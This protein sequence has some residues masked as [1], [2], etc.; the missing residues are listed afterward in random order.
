MKRL[1]WLGLLAIL[2][3]FLTALTSKPG[4]S[5]ASG[6]GQVCC[7]EV[8]ELPELH[9]PVTVKRDLDGVPHISARNDHDAY[10]VQGFLHARDRL[11]QMDAARRL[12][13]GTL[14]ELVGP[15]ALSDDVQLRTL[16]FR[17]GAQ[18]SWAALPSW[19]QANLRAYA[20]GVNAFLESDS[21]LPDEY[22]ALELSRAQPWHPLDT[23]VILKGVLFSRTFDFTLE[24]ELTL[25]LAEF[26]EAGESGG[27][28]GTAL[29]FEDIYR[30]QPFY[31]AV[32][33][34]PS[35][36]S[37]SA[38][39]S[40]AA[41]S[42]RGQLV[43]VKRH[44]GGRFLDALRRWRDRLDL[45][46][47]LRKLLSSQGRGSNW[48]VLSGDL[49][50]SGRPILAGDPHL[51][52]TVPGFWYQNQLIVS[53]DPARGNL[54]ASG[55]SVPGVP[56]VG[57]GCNQRL[58]WTISTN[59]LDLVDTFRET[60]MLD[61]Q[62]LPTHTVYQ[63][64][65]EAVQR[66]AQSFEVNR[67]GNGVLDDR[68]TA[69]VGAA[70]GGQTF[71]VPRRLS[72]PLLIVEPT[73]PN[74]GVGLSV[75]N[76]GLAA[77]QEMRS[78]F[79]LARTTDFESFRFAL[80]YFDTAFNFGYADVD[81]NIGYVATGEVPLREDLEVLQ[82]VDGLPPYLIRDGSGSVRNEW[83]PAQNA[84]PR[85]SL[86]FAI[87]PRDA[88][89]ASFNPESGYLVSANNDPSGLL[90]DNDLFD[91]LRPDGGVDYLLA[92]SV[93]LRAGKINAL[94]E[95]RLASGQGG[96]DREAAEI[97][98][99]NSQFPDAEVLSP[100]VVQ[101]F[102][103]AGRAEAPP[104]LAVLAADGE[105]TEAVERLS[106]WDFSSPTGIAQGYDAG[107]DPESLPQPSPQEISNSVAA[108][109]YATWRSAFLRRVLGGTLQ[110]NGI[111]TG[112]P[113]TFE[114]SLA[115]VRRLLEDFP[116]S[117][118][119][120][121]SGLDFFHTPE[122]LSAEDERDLIILQSL[123][124]AL[125]VLSGPTL[126]PAFNFSS[127]QSDYRWGRLHRVM[128]NHPLGGAFSI[129]PSGG[130]SSLAPGLPGLARAGGFET[131]DNGPDGTLINHANSLLY[132]SGASPRWI[133]RLQQPVQ[134][135]FNQ[136]GGQSGDRNSPHYADLL[137]DWLTNRYRP[138]RTQPDQVNGALEGLEVLAPVNQRLFYP[139]DAA[140]DENFTAF[141]AANLSDSAAQVD[142]Q[143][144]SASGDL[145]AQ[146]SEVLAPQGQSARLGRELF[147]GLDLSGR[148]WV[149]IETAL[150][151]A[152]LPDQPFLATFTQ[153]GDFALRQLDGGVAFSPPSSQLFFTRV[154]HGP[155][156]F[157]G[158][159]A[160]TTLS[161]VNPQDH[162]VTL[163][164]RW[165]RP[166]PEAGAISSQ[167]T[168]PAQGVL[169]E[170]LDSLFA[171]EDLPLQ[172]GYLRVDVQDGYLAAASLL[173]ELVSDQSIFLLNATPGNP[174]RESFSAQLAEGPSIFTSLKLVNT[175]QHVRSLLIHSLSEDGSPLQAPLQV[176]LAP[177]QSW[178]DD[179]LAA[180]QG[181]MNDP[182][183][184]GQSSTDAP[185]HAPGWTDDQLGAG[186]SPTDAPSRAPGSTNDPIAVKQGSTKGPL[187][188]Q[189]NA[190]R[191]GSLRVT[192]DGPGVIGDVVFGDPV[193][194][195]FV[196]ALPLQGELL[197][198]AVFP[199]VANL[200][201]LFFT[202]LAFHN[203]S[204]ADAAEIQIRVLSSQGQPTGQ[205]SLSLAPG[206]R[207]S[208]TLTELIP[209]TQ[210]QQGGLIL[211]DSD[212]PI[213]AQALF[214]TNTLTLLSAVPLTNR[215]P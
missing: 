30:T 124:E 128:L 141:A 174:H 61:G 96:F 53:G 188:A 116:Q 81:G 138:L 139:F 41:K 15:E 144:R 148:A 213:V 149:G 172:G 152:P 114:F 87:V 71:I 76:T 86:P 181:S 73:G 18:E 62:G 57:I 63:G 22:A 205:G 184:T 193:Q 40:M 28:D 171:N 137:G 4:H 135:W 35:A 154:H 84:E 126:A 179:P 109:L 103:R 163:T 88:M 78:L 67:L 89:P 98:Q 6:A 110:R 177:G 176:D 127:N 215:D 65:P 120:G 64:Q 117:Q 133:A 94:I 80:D 7:T 160:S 202:G 44:L 123:N 156:A 52:L 165:I 134:A 142:W 25:N 187:A 189:Q 185:A 38:A 59:P 58:C 113:D 3:L 121:D 19:A 46:P 43:S 201:G 168:L 203:P 23:L 26:Q 208:Q 5:Q 45:S 20:Q 54:D 166:Q 195:S 198:Q 11:F 180:E 161:V 39:P 204:E 211:I 72:G 13:S 79:L 68:L 51:D 17:R 106:R 200:E 194:G 101:A 157:R 112:T 119:R 209:A 147:Q 132:D 66:I 158:R 122:D 92:F 85:Q 102:Q 183:A 115:A 48:W 99:A 21:A 182:L 29:F 75:Q 145:L 155:G 146:T 90:E 16:G 186:Q 1:A 27:F 207:L 12:F 10:M 8:L 14:A 97:M 83:L 164:L 82:R 169:R 42:V 74:S 50:E 9:F 60:L 108:T 107:D 2:A 104:I 192:S 173:V 170:S 118:G 159:D 210:G 199:H 70:S 32:T 130:L 206:Q 93:S 100:H 91:Q 190:T 37:P 31:P 214:G 111:T 167:R 162:P 150:P 129:P 178:E 56:G 95:D 143:A 136:A 153:K 212:R 49:T 131:I 36:E 197:Q 55:F 140:D 47:R 77:T 33:A 105:L 196:A 191:V 175:S 24:I 34:S 151:G 125:S 69:S